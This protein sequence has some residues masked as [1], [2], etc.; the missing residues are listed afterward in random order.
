VKKLFRKKKIDLDTN[1]LTDAAQ[2]KVSEAFI[3]FQQAHDALDEAQDQLTEIYLES[4]KKIDSLKAQLENE[5][6]ALQKVK[7]HVNVNEKLKEQI[8]PFI[9]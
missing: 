7:D 1:A 3:M 9:Q 2:G 8:K 4:A 6:N 5:K